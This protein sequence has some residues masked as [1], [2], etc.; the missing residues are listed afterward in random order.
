MKYFKYI[1]KILII[2]EVIIAMALAVVLC[3][4]P[5]DIS[6]KVGLLIGF[7][8]FFVIFYLLD[9]LHNRYLDDM[10]E[11]LTFLIEELV[12]NH[13]VKVFSELEDT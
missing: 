9:Y 6:V 3:F 7:V 4:T 13:E 12:G 2:L 5:M 1:R 10:L 8:I 11:Q